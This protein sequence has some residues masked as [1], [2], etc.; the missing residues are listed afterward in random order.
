MSENNQVKFI[1]KGG[2]IIPIRSKSDK[3]N[4]VNLLVEDKNKRRALIGGSGLIAGYAAQKLGKRPMRKALLFTVAA[5]V[6]MQVARSI[7]NITHTKV[8]KGES[9]KAAAKRV[10]KK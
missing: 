4:G 9:N 1:R 6:G 3:K 8:K 5:N 7:A 2:R 10:I